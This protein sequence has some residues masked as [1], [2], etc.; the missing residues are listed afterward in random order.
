MYANG[1]VFDG[2]EVE[3]VTYNI[4]D[5]NK[6]GDGTFPVVIKLKQKEGARAVER[7]EE[8]TL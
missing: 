3:S 1:T 2:E 4:D 6:K 8:I 5:L 7:D